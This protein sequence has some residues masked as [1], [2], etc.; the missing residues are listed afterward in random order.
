MPA[1]PGSCCSAST[2]DRGNSPGRHSPGRHKPGDISPGSPDRRRP[3]G[4]VCG[5]RGVSSSKKG[6]VEMTY[7]QAI[8]GAALAFAVTL[9]I[10]GLAKYGDAALQATSFELGS[11]PTYSHQLVVAVLNTTE[12][13]VRF[14]RV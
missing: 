13:A 10:L 4:M 11:P 1:T 12:G 7:P 3:Y 6:V 8:L 2:A 9:L 14:R 5:Y